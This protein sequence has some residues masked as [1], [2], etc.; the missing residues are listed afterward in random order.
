M[1]QFWE[2]FE[3]GEIHF[4]DK[5]QFELKSEFSPDHDHKQSEYTQEFFIFI[6][7]ALQINPQTYS[8]D[9][10]FRA[11]TNLIRFQTPDLTFE[12]LLDPNFSNSPLTKL[13]ALQEGEVKPAA[14]QAMEKELKLFANVFRKTLRNAVR[15]LI[16][17][18]EQSESGEEIDRCKTNILELLSQVERT[19]KVILAQ[20]NAILLRPEGVL[21]YPVFENIREVMSISLNSLLANLLETVR[22][23]SDPRLSSCDHELSTILLEEKKYRED[24]LKEPNQFDKDSA[25][26]ESI[27][28][29]SG[30]LNKFILDA[31]QLKTRKLAINE[32]YRSLIGGFAAAMA[33]FLYLMAFIWQ[34]A[35]FVINSLPFVFFT[36][37]LYVI[38]DR[39]KE[40]LKNLSYKHVFRWFPDY[41]TE[42]SLPSNG[43]VVG[44]VHESFSFIDENQVPLDIQHL[45]NQ[46]FHTY[47]EMIKRQE[48]VIYFKKKVIVY[49][50][51]DIEAPLQG[52]SIIFRFNLQGFFS[53]GSDPHEPYT[54]IDDETLELIHIQLPKVYH[55]NIILKNSYL[56]M[57][58]SE[59][60][61]YKKVRIV[62]DKEGVKRIESLL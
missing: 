28:H 40:E 10:F 46:G 55:V 19:K 52:L 57:N 1:D 17:S 31:L 61:E 47:L 7:A 38:K 45:R 62:A 12:E 60:V 37:M 8:K 41:T 3:A 35:I 2:E 21:L 34:G 16:R 9:E 25:A 11:E 48:N 15:P 23:K 22:L 53:K 20:Q 56:Q 4:R 43:M 51:K 24:R 30:L 14:L 5:W 59:K 42:I 32:K 29:Q 27:L 26:N 18:I 54:T 39:I 49:E 44:K 6:P 13:Q 50:R 33:M 36:V 58:M